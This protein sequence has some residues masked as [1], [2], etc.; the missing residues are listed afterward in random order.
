MAKLYIIPTPI[1]NFQDMTFRALSIL[2]EIDLILAEDTRTTQKLLN[3]FKIKTKLSSYHNYNEHKNLN[4]WITKLKSGTTIGLVSEAGTPAISDPGF[5]LIREAIQ[6]NIA[7]ESL[8]GA[9][10][11]LPALLNSGIPCSSFVFEGFLP[12]KKGRL[13]KLDILGK[14]KRTI[15]IYESP[16]RLIKTLKQL[17]D[18]L[19][20]KRLISVSRELTKMFE[21][22]KRG[23]IVDIISYF[24]KNQPKGEFVIIVSGG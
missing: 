17:K 24:E 16:H 3:N 2:S 8:P 23:M 12:T 21:E 14:E 7:I 22:T 15:I 19:G 5:L 9:S 13:K 4:K 1:G 20:E 10:A 18:V 11:F 6:H